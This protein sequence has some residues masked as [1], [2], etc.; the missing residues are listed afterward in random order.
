MAE[1]K[2]Y[3]T[4]KGGIK[5]E[6]FIGQIEGS[7]V[8]FPVPERVI[9]PLKQGFGD[10]V[11]PIV[12]IGDKVKCGEIIGISEKNISSPVHASISGY[13]RDIIKKNYFGRETKFIII[14]GDGKNDEFEKL[15][16]HDKKFEEMSPSEIGEKLYLSGVTSLGRAGIPTKFKSSFVNPEDIEYLIIHGIG[17]EIY[18]VLIDKILEGKKLFNFVKGIEV[19]K[20]LFTNI[21]KVYLAINRYEKKFIEEIS[22]LTYDFEWLEISLIEPKYPFGYDE[23]LIPTLLRK[24][25]PYGYSA[26][27]IGVIVLNIRAILYVYEAIFE[28]KPFIETIIGLGGPSFKENL[29]LKVRIGT[30]IKNITKEYLK[31]DKDIRIILN[32]LITGEK[33]DDLDLPIDRATNHIIAIKENKERRFLSF[34]RPNFRGYSYTNAFLNFV[35]KYPDTNMHGEKRPCI[36]C[37]Y[38]YEVC[39]VNIIPHLIIKFVMK[40]I[41]DERLMEYGIFKCIECNLCSFVC[42]SKIPV[43]HYIKEGQHKLIN[44]GCDRSQ[45]I[46]PYF[47][48][49][50]IEEYRGVKKL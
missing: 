5:F 32:S 28:N 25:F 16:Y 22:K 17:S 34:L 49:K 20:K 2:K 37:G 23:V 29:H 8:E 39:P 14:E 1:I 15:K 24:D 11:E 3:K 45:C 40:N 50:G 27:N 6:N 33:I 13:V 9:I 12:K 41:F 4:L 48:L 36:N 43:S 21:K 35:D 44:I 26:A 10:E 46:L 38:C 42:P 7:V 19:L 47:Q 31:D 18:N 30:P